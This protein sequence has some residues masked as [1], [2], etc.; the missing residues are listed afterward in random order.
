MCF[1]GSAIRSHP[2]PVGGAIRSLSLSPNAFWPV[3]NGTNQVQMTSLSGLK[4]S[5]TFGKVLHN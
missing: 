2:K 1:D 4:W 3:M 5:S